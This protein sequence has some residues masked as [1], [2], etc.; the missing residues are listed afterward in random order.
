MAEVTWGSLS[1]G[2]AEKVPMHPEDFAVLLEWVRAK[3]G[4]E[5][6]QPGSLSGK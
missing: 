1:D 4:W 5:R 3:E 2:T 6:A